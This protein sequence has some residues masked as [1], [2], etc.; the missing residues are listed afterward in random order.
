MGFL[1][2]P[3]FVPA[4]PRVAKSLPSNTGHRGVRIPPDA[5][6]NAEKRRIER[7]LLPLEKT[8]VLHCPGLSE[9]KHK[10]TEFRHDTVMRFIVALLYP[11]YDDCMGSSCHF[12]LLTSATSQARTQSWTGKHRFVG[13]RCVLLCREGHV[14]G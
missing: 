5:L 7:R 10:G 2:K 6:C 4:V 1:E 8:N 9:T 3:G 11:V 12:S 14:A 13:H